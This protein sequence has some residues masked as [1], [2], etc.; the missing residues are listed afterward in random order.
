MPMT[1]ILIYWR[2]I[3]PILFSISGTFEALLLLASCTKPFHTSTHLYCFMIWKWKSEKMFRIAVATSRVEGGRGSTRICSF[4]IQFVAEK[5][6]TFF[7][8]LNSASENASLETRHNS[9]ALREGVVWK[10]RNAVE[11]FPQLIDLLWAVTTIF[12]VICYTQ[13]TKHLP[14]TRSTIAPPGTLLCFIIIIYCT[15]CAVCI[16][17][18]INSR[19]GVKSERT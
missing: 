11:I 2:I 15:F 4:W 9:R 5:R 19:M 7:C 10:L 8:K 1:H 14:N 16:I 18:A 17:F 12:R 6:F 13:R 3:L